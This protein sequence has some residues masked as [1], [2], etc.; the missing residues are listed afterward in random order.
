MGTEKG[1]MGTE[2]GEMGTIAAV[3][4]GSFSPLIFSP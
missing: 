3:D 1:E 4:I 2:K